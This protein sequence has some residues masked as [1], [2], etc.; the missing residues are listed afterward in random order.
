MHEYNNNTEIYSVQNIDT[1][2]KTAFLS[3]SLVYCDVSK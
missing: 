2:L 1:T 3:K